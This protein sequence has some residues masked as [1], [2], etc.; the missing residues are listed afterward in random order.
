MSS[1]PADLKYTKSHEWVQLDG[2][3]A[4][5][6]I[7]EFAQSELGD[8]VFVEL[9]EVGRNL[10]LD[11]SFGT[12][13]SVKT[14]SELYAPV[15]GVVVESNESLTKHSELVNSAPYKEG[16]MVKIKVSDVSSLH[17]LLT[18]DE[19]AAIVG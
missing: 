10:A 13:E 18:A 17:Q 4:T 19:Y 14:V 1:I 7:T 5:V 11:E 9:P 15:A 16:F 3:V 12:V 2:D 8:V 6:G